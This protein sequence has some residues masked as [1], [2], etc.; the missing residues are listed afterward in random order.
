MDKVPQY[1]PNIRPPKM[2]KKLRFMRGPEPLHNFL[3]HKQYGIMVTYIEIVN[4]HYSSLNYVLF[5]LQAVV[6]C[7][8]DTLKWFV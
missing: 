5:R 7:D 3:L 4:I 1:P 8:G 2:Q 6:V